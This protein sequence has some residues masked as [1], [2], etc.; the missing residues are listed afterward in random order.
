VLLG[1]SG[2]IA[3]Y[4]SC[5]IARHFVK[6]GVIVQP[7]IT[8]NAARFVAPL[9]FESLTGR[10]CFTGMFNGKTKTDEAGA[11]RHIDFGRDYNVM[12]VAPATAN[13]A[14]KFS[15]GIA[16]D[17]L[18]TTY[19]CFEGDVVIAP[20]MNSRM[21]SHP[22]VMRNL[23]RIR[24]DGV[25]IIEPT[26]GDLACG[27]TGMGRM[28]DIGIITGRVEKLLGL[29]GPWQGRKVVVTTGATREAIDPVRFISNNSTGDFGR[30][31]AR[32]LIHYGADVKL[33]EANPPSPVHFTPD[34]ERFVV[35]TADEIL[36]R[37][38]ELADDADWVF[39]FAA[40]SDFTPVMQSANKIKK[41]E[42]KDALKIELA[43][44]VD[45]LVELGK[46]KNR[47]KLVGVSAESTDVI[48][49]SAVKL[50]E[51]GLCAILAVDVGAESHPFGA[52]PMAGTVIFPD[53]RNVEIESL[54]KEVLARRFVDE[55]SD[56]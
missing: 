16:D 7:V 33:V 22:T 39:M 38:I 29:G 14:A 44:T 52:T 42:Q 19:L 5:E 9:T 36:M 56:I 55:L 54:P 4:K 50:K 46:L 25:E 37:T 31:V 21:W 10:P 1:V 18:S 13:I 47:P 28:A 30:A 15:A 34:C 35:E 6:L 2:G 8:E 45:V 43:G 27:E 3:A 23:E 41:K 12:L 17:L 40:V 24:E 53:G 49:N 32:Q 26:V 11:F 51:K 20:A 48:S